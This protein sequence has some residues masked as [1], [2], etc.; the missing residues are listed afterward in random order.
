MRRWGEGNPVLPDSEATVLSL[1]R[2]FGHQIHIN[3]MMHR[4]MGECLHST[5]KSMFIVLGSLLCVIV[6]ILPAIGPTYWEV[7][8]PDVYNLQTSE[9][10]FPLCTYTYEHITKPIPQQHLCSYAMQ[11]DLNLVMYMHSMCATL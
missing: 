11:T 4:T 9:Y 5:L 1:V 8:L 7:A 3:L 10:L 6:Y 2:L